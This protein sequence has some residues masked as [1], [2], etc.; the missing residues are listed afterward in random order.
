M[1]LLAL[2]LL[3]ANVTAWHSLGH[4]TV[5]RIARLHL[6]EINGGLGDQVIRYVEERLRPLS[7][8]CGEQNY[9]FT[10]SA[11]WPDKIK[12]QRWLSMS[13][14]HFG[15]QPVFKD[16]YTPKTPPI[17]NPENV[18]WAILEALSYLQSNNQ[19]EEGKSKNILG[20]SLSLRNLIHF[21]G[22]IHQPLHTT[23][24]YS[25]TNP[26]GDEGGN[27]FKIK[28]YP[29]ESW[30]NLHFIWDHLFDLGT[31]VDSPLTE[32]QYNE[33]TAFANEIKQK[34][35]NDDVFNQLINSNVSP[36]SWMKEGLQIVD[37]FIY[38]GIVED[39]ELPQEYIEK[40]KEI[41]TLRI[42]LAGKR[43]SV[44]L[45]EAFMKKRYPDLVR[46]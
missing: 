25:I 19:D 13:N 30:N 6:E 39:Q 2:Y 16:S 32:D 3:L 5:A 22:D 27:L 23:E 24:R 26:N 40:G 43:L 21:V 29:Q 1:R 35:E 11:T 44:L 20:K 28:H 4:L 10:E 37:E 33:V 31:E 45:Q 41:V 18:S 38:N 15:D 9:P 8:M 42:A 36:D 12:Y 34:Y 46:F 14:W 7:E 17:R